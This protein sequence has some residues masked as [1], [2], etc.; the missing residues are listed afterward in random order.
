MRRRG[1]PLQLVIGGVGNAKATEW[2]PALVAIVESGKSRDAAIRALGRIGPAAKDAVPA[3]VAVLRSGNDPD[4]Q[5]SVAALVRIGGPAATALIALLRDK[6]AGVRRR[7]A[8]TLS[9]IQMVSGP[10]PAP[11]ARVAI[12]TLVEAL[13]GADVE[14]ANL[15]A[16][17]LPLFG[18]SRCPLSS[19][20][21]RDKQGR[22]QGAR[23]T[24]HRRDCPDD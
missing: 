6:D 11:A 8:E 24:C 23:R 20:R 14:F 7:A 21:S 15:A 12:P 4:R 2:V 1:L 13:H 22:F 19:T 5:A 3:L 9:Q 10:L 16:N 18:R 17:I